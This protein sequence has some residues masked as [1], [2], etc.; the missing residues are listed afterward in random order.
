[1]TNYVSGT[2]VYMNKLNLDVFDSIDKPFILY[3]N[4]NN[5]WFLTEIED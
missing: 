3:R 5:T 2:K 1:M 4:H